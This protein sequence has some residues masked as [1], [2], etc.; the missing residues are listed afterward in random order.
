MLSQRNESWYLY[1]FFSPI[2]LSPPLCGSQPEEF[3]SEDDPAL[4]VRRRNR[5][6]ILS[7]PE[8][9]ATQMSAADLGMQRYAASQGEEWHP[10]EPPDPLRRLYLPDLKHKSARQRIGAIENHVSQRSLITMDMFLDGFNGCLGAA[11]RTIRGCNLLC[12]DSFVEMFNAKAPTSCNF[13][14]DFV[15]CIPPRVFT[16][17][18]SDTRFVTNVCLISLPDKEEAILF[19]FGLRF[20]ELIPSSPGAPQLPVY[21]VWERVDGGNLVDASKY[22]FDVVKKA[23]EEITRRILLASK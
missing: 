8:I 2:F 6:K 12:R 1:T 23:Y 16:I 19:S 22:L 18:S 7:S 11:L 17:D 20:S 5:S 9:P 21:H 3:K 14:V 13:S 4:V 15:S 10:N